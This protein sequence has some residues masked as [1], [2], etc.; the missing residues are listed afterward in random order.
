MGHRRPVYWGLGASGREAPNPIANLSMAV[1]RKKMLQVAIRLM[2][3]GYT[4]LGAALDRGVAGSPNCLM[5]ATFCV[6][7]VLCGLGG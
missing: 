4:V 2:L 7:A 1:V 6:I 5:F 3:G